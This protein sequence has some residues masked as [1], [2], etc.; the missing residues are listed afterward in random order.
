MENSSQTQL[1][2]QDASNSSHKL[3]VTV[4]C[5][6]FVAETVAIVIGNLLT[7]II[8]AS[9]ASV[10]KPSSYLIMSLALADLFIGLFTLPLW[11]YQSG[12]GTLWH[13]TLPQH[14]SILVA[15]IGLDIFTNLA[16][17]SNLA[18]ISVERLFATLL[19]WRHRAT[20]RWQ[21]L[22][23]IAVV[24]MTCA[25]SAAIY[26]IARFVV[27]S[28]LGIM[29]SWLPY[30][31]LL[32]LVI[33]ASY[34]AILVKMRR[35]SHRRLDRERKLTITLFIATAFSLVAYLPMVV[36]GVLHFALG[37]EM[38]NLFMNVL[39]FFNFGN[40]LVNPILYSFRMPDFRRAVRSIFCPPKQR[41]QMCHGHVTIPP[42]DDCVTP[43]SFR[44]TAVSPTM[45]LRGVVSRVPDPAV[46]RTERQ[47]QRPWIQGESGQCEGLDPV[48]QAEICDRPRLSSVVS[49][50]DAS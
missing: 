26:I 34:I 11:I 3:E 45:S 32:L 8:F 38:G 6:V 14:G 4:W 19:P 27:L 31:C 1:S 28:A 33:C 48:S 9:D 41:Q 29:Y 44:M 21:F 22:L 15:F 35:S 24:W 36:L 37:K 46:L 2:D 17:I 18:A 13:F 12:L 43:F 39:S 50:C 5:A 23:L 10:R 47:N 30:F 25:L 49:S 20:S 7:V 16:S 40:S 42:A